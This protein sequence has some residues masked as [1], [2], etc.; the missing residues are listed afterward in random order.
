MSHTRIKYRFEISQREGETALDAAKRA[1]EE[2]HQRWV[3]V[4]KKKIMQ[5]FKKRA[6]EKGYEVDFKEAQAMQGSENV[7][8]L[9]ITWA[10]KR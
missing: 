3:P 2:E 6:E 10:R 7:H 9:K 8:A 1:L 4:A 5:V